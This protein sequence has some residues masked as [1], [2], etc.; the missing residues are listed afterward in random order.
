MIKVLKTI[1]YDVLSTLYKP[2]WA[3]LLLSC[4]FMFLYQYAKEHGWGKE[5]IVRKVFLTRIDFFK[6]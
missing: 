3:S 5:N 6:E 1:I 4:M 2:F